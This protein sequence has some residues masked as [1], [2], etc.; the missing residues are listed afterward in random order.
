MSC[1][2]SNS[3]RASGI[4]DTQQEAIEQARKIAQNQGS[5]VSI[6]GKR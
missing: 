4:Y 1:K 5:E 6:Y 2:K 3:K